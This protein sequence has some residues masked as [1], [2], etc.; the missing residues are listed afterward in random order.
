MRKVACPTYLLIHSSAGREASWPAARVGV[1]PAV[2]IRI[3]VALRLRGII[4]LQADDR[5]KTALSD[6]SL[7][8]TAFPASELWVSQNLPATSTRSP[9]RP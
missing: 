4:I 7:A 5:N 8:M 3:S 9:S 1:I 2:R 6:G